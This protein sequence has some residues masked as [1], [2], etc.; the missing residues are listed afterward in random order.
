MY[1][2]REFAAAGGLISY[3]SS[4]TEAYR[5]AGQ[6]ADRILKGEKPAARDSTD[7]IRAGY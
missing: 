3:A 6:Y 1:T 7:E 5:Q 4:I 2:F